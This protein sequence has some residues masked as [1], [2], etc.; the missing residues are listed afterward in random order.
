MMT[1]E[2]E[3]LEYHE[4]VGLWLRAEYRQ[5]DRVIADDVIRD[6]CY[7][8]DDLPRPIHY[9]LDIGAH[10]GA[11][12]VR[13]RKA[14]PEARICCVEANPENAAALCRNVS[15]FAAVRIAA[16]TYEDE[17]ELL[18]TVW[19][20]T[21]N[22]GGSF[23]EPAGSDHW[24]RLPNADEYRPAGRVPTVTIESL[25]DELGWPRID[26]L[27]LDCE[28]SEFSILAGTR[29]LDKIGVIVG[30]YH[31]EP[32][33]RRLVRARFA[34]KQWTRDILRPGTPGLFR[35]SRPNWWN[36]A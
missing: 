30:E 13:M 16:C 34:P 8:V 25:L 22:T 27:K 4:D 35:L 24:R 17:V 12:A 15:G 23:V 1:D 32:R 11:F 21:A 10:I 6:D 31:S 7:R 33:F 9:V 36:M 28:G 20:G 18:S 5:A 2:T 26:V 3:T 14:R 19:P 29:S